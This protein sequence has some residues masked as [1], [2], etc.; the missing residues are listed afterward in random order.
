[1]SN[2]LS[3]AIGFVHIQRRKLKGGRHGHGA[4]ASTSYNLVRHDRLAGKVRYVVALGSLKEPIGHES[5]VIRF[6][7]TAI[8]RM[9]RHGLDAHQRRHIASEM[10]R[11]GARPPTS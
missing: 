5:D 6:W 4:A 11:K 3:G 7:Q 2:S 10:I 1:M 8:F 9:S